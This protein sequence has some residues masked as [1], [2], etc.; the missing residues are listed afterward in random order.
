MIKSLFLPDSIFTQH[1]I[2][3]ELGRTQITACQLQQTGSKIKIE[4][5]IT[6]PI[7]QNSEQ[8]QDEQ[9]VSALS[10]A[11]SQLKGDQI[12]LSLSNNLIIFKELTVPFLDYQKIKL[13]LGFE[14]ESELPF[15]LHEAALDFII[16][17]QDLVQKTSTLL[18][19]VTQKKHLDGFLEIFTQLKNK[20]NIRTVTIDLF[21]LYGLCSLLPDQE[22]NNYQILLDLGKNSITII[23]L[24]NGQIKL[25]RNLPYGINT[26]INRIAS[27]SGKSSNEITEGLMRYGVELPNASNS[28]TEFKKLINDL[29][30]TM[31]SF[32]SQPNYQPIKQILVVESNSQIKD[33]TNYLAEQ[34]SLTY[35]LFDPR[36]LANIKQVV[37]ADGLSLNQNYLP[38]IAAAVQ[39]PINQNFN[40]SPNIAAENKIIDYQIITAMTLTLAIFGS[41]Y[42]I[43]SMQI[44]RTE[45]ILKKYQ[46]EALRKLKS[47]FNINDPS[48]DLSDYI[49]QA[50]VKVNGEKKLWFSFSNQTKYVFSKYLQELSLAIDL[51]KINLDLK[52]LIISDGI[53]TLQGSVDK[54]DDLYPL[55]MAL[56]EISVFKHITFPQETSFVI[57]IT[58]QQGYEEAS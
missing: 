24:L 56:R 19:A 8:M 46:T 17:S 20:L 3:L 37:L 7:E 16:T 58:L 33:L 32:S 23:Y 29:I 2:S 13:V 43:S 4:K 9:T 54:F 39:A 27:A 34:T 36:K 21:G 26:I 40:L 47:T 22:I 25:I 38:V 50:E 12:R 5:L 45:T 11:L 48:T 15:P 14:I 44:S 30:F 1:V 35:E 28:Q 18:I 53:M 41:L 6:V 10:L 49:N 55:E 57:K 42:A 51:N 31:N 52:K